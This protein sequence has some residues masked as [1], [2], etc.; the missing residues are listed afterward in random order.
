MS[1]TFEVMTQEQ[2]EEIAY[3]WHYEGDYSFYDMEADE[4]DLAGFLNPKERGENIFAVWCTH[5][6]VGFF[7]FNKTDIHTVDIGLGM[8]PNM[9][10]NGLGLDFVQAGIMFCKEKYKPRHI[11][12]AVATFNERAIKV[13]KKV[14]FEAVGTFVQET[15]GS[16]FEFLKMIYSNSDILN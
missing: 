8:K 3:S 9:A 11:T 4:E 1:Y 7:N 16:R 15:N 5:N 13:Y 2:A 12:L 6:M 14:G 10:G